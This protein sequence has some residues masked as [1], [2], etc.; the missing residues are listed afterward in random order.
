MKLAVVFGGKSFEH[1]ISI[2][3]AIALKK[4]LTWELV[5][6]FCD[7]DHNF[8][9]IPTDTINSKRFSSKEYLKDK[10]LF[11]KQEGF[12]FKKMLG[13]AKLE[14][15]VVLNLIHGAD[16]EDGKIR[17]LFDFFNIPK[18]NIIDANP[19]T[20]VPIPPCISATLIYCENNAPDRATNEFDIINPNIL[21]FFSFTPNPITRFSLSPNARKANPNLDVNI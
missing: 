4:V 16:G 21:S 18:P 2:V 12:F 5:Y 14:Y 13:E 20:I 6:I 3:S 15:D 19:I 17:A 8:Y 7:N 9:H 10:A 1:E 11:L